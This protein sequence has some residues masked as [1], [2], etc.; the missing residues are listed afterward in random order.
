[1][2]Q[3]VVWM[4]ATECYPD[5]WVPL[6]FLF[7]VW[8]RAFFCVGIFWRW[9][10]DIFLFSDHIRWFYV[11][12]TF[13]FFQFRKMILFTEPC[14][15]PYS[16]GIW[17]QDWTVLYKFQ[18]HH[19]FLSLHV[20]S[21]KQKSMRNKSKCDKECSND[22]IFLNVYIALICI[23][24]W[25]CQSGQDQALLLSSLLNTSTA[26]QF[27]GCDTITISYP[28]IKSVLYSKMIQQPCCWQ[29]KKSRSQQCLQFAF[30]V[31]IS[32]FLVS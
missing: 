31:L 5:V 6:T 11:L 2:V 3:H 12:R 29:I 26:H 24:K 1:M 14:K 25:Q 30:Q 22:W 20:F 8:V 16:T 15:H 23:Q 10:F 13:S 27:H 18:Y 9:H 4:S 32:A 21:R 28:M 17:I 19:L 7:G